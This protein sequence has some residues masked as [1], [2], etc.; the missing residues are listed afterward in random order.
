LIDPV[1]RK[2]IT[3]G[4]GH[5]RSRYSPLHAK[6]IDRIVWFARGDK[7]E[8]K[9]LLKGIIS[10]GYFRKIGYGL[11]AKWEIEIVENDY[12]VIANN[13]IMKTLPVCEHLKKFDSY[14]LNYGSCV[15]PYWH[16]GNF[17]EIAIPL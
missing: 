15:P 4:T 2:T 1:K 9:R 17:R 3:P 12:S 7:K 16:A 8:C 13:R 10:L 6:L 5:L 14:R 11:V